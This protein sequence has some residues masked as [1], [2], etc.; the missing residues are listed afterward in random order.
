MF[1]CYCRI[2][3]INLNT[4]WLFYTKIALYNSRRRSFSYFVHIYI[5]IHTIHAWT[6]Y[7][8]L[9]F[10]DMY[11]LQWQHWNLPFDIISHF[12]IITLAYRMCVEWRGVK[13]GLGGSPISTTYT[14]CVL[15][16]DEKLNVYGTHYTTCNVLEMNM[17]LFFVVSLYV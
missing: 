12:P 11:T 16:L 8:Q 13:G 9:F 4:F 15:Y 14:L 1:C 5:K 10:M 3:L 2:E 7:T 6:V 17:G